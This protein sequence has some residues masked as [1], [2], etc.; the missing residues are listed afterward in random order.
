MGKRSTAL[1]VLLLFS[2]AA[3]GGGGSG[4]D[5]SS[6]DAATADAAPPDAPAAVTEA[7]I[8]GT[9]GVYVQLIDKFLTC[10]PAIDILLVQG[11][12][13]AAAVSAA[14]SGAVDPYLA[15]GTVAL[16]SRD[17]LNACLDYLATVSCAD[18]DLTTGAGPCDIFIGE[19]PDAGDCDI[20]EQCSNA[21][22]CDHSG[23]GTCGACTAR[24]ADGLACNADEQ[25][26]NGACVGTQCGHLGDVGDPCFDDADCLGERVCDTNTNQCAAAPTWVVNQACTPN[27]G[28][29]DPFDTGLYCSGNGQCS[30]FLT[31]DT[32]CR[33]NGN[34]T[35]I[36][37]VRSYDYC[38]A[39]A[40]AVCAP[41]TLVTI[42]G[43]ACGMLNGLK[44][45]TGLVCGPNALQ[46]GTCVSYQGAGDTCT[47]GG[48]ETDRCDLFL[49]CLDNGT[50]T[51]CVYND[52]SGSCPL[53]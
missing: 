11:R 4:D 30:P 50:S 48:A 42:E 25:C 3:C 16:P 7:D 51:T 23:G 29:C 47:N 14:C 20:T 31:L 49:N 27:S 43:Q 2:L 45:D 6:P 37:D 52:Y 46:N 1:H 35:G 40:N 39:G 8:C 21:S 41:P 22:Y 38:P 15:D 5:A 34:A 10:T 19:V 17:Q 9:D 26:T 36:C 33:T 12:A 24:A 28:D 13:D 53:P 32:A 44:C 18:Y